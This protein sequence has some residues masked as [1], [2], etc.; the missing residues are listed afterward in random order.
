MD[1]IGLYE[2][3]LVHTH[4]HIVVKKMDKIFNSSGENINS[5]DKEIRKGKK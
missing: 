2:I 5:D 4:Y 1:N 3:I